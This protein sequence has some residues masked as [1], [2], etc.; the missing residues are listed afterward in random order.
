MREPD[1]EGLATHGGPESCVCVCEGAGEALTGA[2]VGWAI[3]PRNQW[4]RGADA[5][6]KAEGNTAGSV[7]ASWRRAPRGLRT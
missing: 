4:H 6:T 1:T 2:R 5:V 3:E 7:S